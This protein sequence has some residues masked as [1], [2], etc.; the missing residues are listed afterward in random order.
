MSSV[1]PPFHTEFR[2]PGALNAGSGRVHRYRLAG[3]RC[4]ARS[5]DAMNPLPYAVACRPYFSIAFARPS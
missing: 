5:G 3:A 2:K 1:S 4:Q